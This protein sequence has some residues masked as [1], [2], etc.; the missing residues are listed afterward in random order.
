[1]TRKYQKYDTEKFKSEIP[2][3]VNSRVEIYFDTENEK[4]FQEIIN[5]LNDA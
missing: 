2:D 4:N 3:L 1:V 5:I